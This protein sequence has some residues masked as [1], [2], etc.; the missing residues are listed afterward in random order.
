[1]VEVCALLSANGHCGAEEAEQYNDML[2]RG[3][4]VYNEKLWTGAGAKPMRS[5]IAAYNIWSLVAGKMLAR[6]LFFCQTRLSDVA[7]LPL[8]RPMTQ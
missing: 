4:R 8:Q 5:S 6:D 2:E 3:S 1:M 7:P